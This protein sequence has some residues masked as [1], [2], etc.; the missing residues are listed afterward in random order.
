MRWKPEPT[1]VPQNF[2]ADVIRRQILREVWSPA[3]EDNT[4][5]LRIHMTHLRQKLEANPQH[6]KTDAGIGCRF[7]E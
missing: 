2:S 1:T 3:A 5:D 7:V 6:L 4:H